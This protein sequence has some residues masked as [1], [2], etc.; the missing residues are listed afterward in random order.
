MPDPKVGIFK[1]YLLGAFLIIAASAG[2]T[3]VAAFDELNAVT[4]AFKNGQLVDLQ[5]GLANADAGKPQTIMLIGSDTRAKGARDY[6]GQRGLSDTMM[7]VRL[8]PSKKQIAV[9]SLPRDLKVHIPGHGVDKLNAAYAFGGAK[10]TLDTVK[11]FTGL[12]VNHVVNIDFR[13]FRKAVNALGCIYVDVDR[14]YFNNN[15]SGGD[16]YA[17]IDIQPG[18]QKICDQDALDY[19]RYRHTDNDIVRAARQQGFLRALKAQVG[20]NR[21]IADR[22]NLIKIFGKYT[23]SDIGSRKTVLRLLKLVIASAGLPIHQVQFKGKLGASYVTA[24]SEA[25]HRLADEFLGANTTNGKKG[26]KKKRKPERPPRLVDASSMGRNIALQVV[27]QGLRKLRVYYP[28]QLVAGASYL[29]PP[30]AY[31]LRGKHNRK[32]RAYRIV[33]SAGAIGE[34]LGVQGTAWKNPPI[35]AGPHETRTVGRN[36]VQVYYDGQRVRL[37]SWKTKQGVYWV[38]NTLT[39]KLSLKQMLAIVRSTKPL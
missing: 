39:Q 17:T 7:L 37:V 24:T 15:T 4:D 32:Y 36:K 11:E 19:V 38:S 34:Y 18:Y 13:G 28:H 16:Q 20:V 8:D 14:R 26:K 25:A 29:A 10:L 5:K 6:T 12:S 35:L 2:A 33:I 31:A 9:L 27:S 23:Q 22:R 3:G 21:I 1:R 30:R